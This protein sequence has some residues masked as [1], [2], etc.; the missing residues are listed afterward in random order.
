[1]QLWKLGCCWGKH[2]PDFYD[3]LLQKRI[4]ICGSERMA[5]GDW[6]LVCHGFQGDALARIASEPVPCTSKPDLK[7]DFARLEIDYEDWNQVAGFDEWY[8]LDD[9]E[10]IYYPKQGGICQIQ[11]NKISKQMGAII[12]KRQGDGMIDNMIKLLE[13]AKQIVL[14]GAPGTGKTYLARQ[15]A[16][17]MILGKTVADD[18]ELSEA[19]K[20]N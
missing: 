7:E 3:M 12:R 9:N 16:M 11:Q 6:V 20:K 19:E 10:K 17:K 14:T 2:K 18:K 1:M 5:K 13:S 15:I 4:V 8:T